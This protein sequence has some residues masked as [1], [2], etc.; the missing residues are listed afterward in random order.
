MRPSY[1][2]VTELV[3]PDLEGCPSW[4]AG[5]LTSAGLRKVNAAIRDAYQYGAQLYNRCRP[6]DQPP[7]PLMAPQ[8]KP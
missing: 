8:P 2:D 1:P 6:S 7:V 4:F 3:Q 5:C